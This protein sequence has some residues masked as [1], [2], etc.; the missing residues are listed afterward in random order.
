MASAV[1]APSSPAW[2]VNA[3]FFAAALVVWAGF[4]FMAGP[5][6]RYRGLDRPV[7]LSAP[8]NALG[9]L[10][11]VGMFIVGALV[12]GPIAGGDFR[13][14]L[15]A[16]GFAV[17]VWTAEQTSSRSTMDGWLI[18]QNENPGP[19]RGAPYAR[20]LLDYLYLVVAVLG[21]YVASRMV[22][23]TG[24]AGAELAPPSPTTGVVG[25]DPAR[26][27]GLAGLLGIDTSPKAVQDGLLALALTS[28]GAA[29]AIWFL[30]GPPTNQTLR[31]QVYFA[32]GVGLLG[33]TWVAKQMSKSREPF[34]YMLAPLVLGIVGLVVAALRPGLVIP[35]AYLNLDTIPAWPLARALPVEMVSVGLVAT[36]SMLRPK[37]AGE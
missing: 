20:L 9:G 34:W 23:R 3:R 7:T 37:P 14:P 35:A 15:M 32:V 18:L 24:A 16:V 33:G 30:V 10:A 25:S 8:A 22:C 27:G 2:L 5:L 6:I 26:A 29:V 17:A 1:L 11:F 4:Q 13:R 28:L 19:P 21:A 31:G 36:L 12:A